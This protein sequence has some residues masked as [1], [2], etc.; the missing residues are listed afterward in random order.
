MANL[1][2]VQGSLVGGRTD[3]TPWGAGISAL[4]KATGLGG[5][6]VDGGCRDVAESKALDYPATGSAS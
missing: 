1:K 6:I 2:S 5:T 3:V 4:A